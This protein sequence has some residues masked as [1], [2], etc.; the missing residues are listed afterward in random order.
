MVHTK[1]K[2]FKKTLNLFLLLFL[3]IGAIA[4][5]LVGVFYRTEIDSFLSRIK[6]QET[7][8]VSLQG[9]VIGD[10][11]KYIV[12]DLLF[13]AYQNELR[14][15]LNTD[16]ATWTQSVESEYIAMAEHKK[17]YDQLRYLDH[18]GIEKVR[19]NYNSGTPQAVATDQLQDKSQRY[20]FT[21]SIVLNNNQ[22]FV[23]PLDLNIE[24]GAVE[25]PLKPMIRLATPVFDDSGSKRG[26]V[27]INYLAETLLKD[28][29]QSGNLGHGEAMLVNS[30]GDW[31]LNQ[32]HKEDEWIFMFPEKVERKF[33]TSFPEEWSEILSQQHG[34]FETQNGMFTFTTIYP[35]M[36]TFAANNGETLATTSYESLNKYF[37]V[38]V[39]YIPPEH[40]K[41]YKN[42]LLVK[43]FMI[44]SG[45]FLIIVLGSWFTALA[46]T[47]R[48]IYQAELIGMALHDTLTGLANRRLF[49]ENLRKGVDH[50]K[51]F[52]RKLGLLYIDLDGFKEVNDQYG[53]EAGDDLLISVGKTLQSLS[54]SSDTIAR[55]GGDEF[56]CILFEVDSIE[57]AVQ[58]GQKIVE[59][60]RD[61]IKIQGK[62]VTV[63][64]SVGVAV[65]PD[66]GTE[67]EELVRRADKAMYKSK[68]GGKNICTQYSKDLT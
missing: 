5:G 25:L 11:F 16:D 30:E 35:L 55:L 41:E 66:H 54:R 68:V 26:I 8:T 50:D 39:S 2:T 43:M 37:W 45:L 65:Y 58:A 47:K 51:R 27:L 56:A 48:R 52:E 7:H 17:V 40:L 60:L 12:S 59:A 62:T 9:K 49:F 18:N 21:D 24:N 3:I 29:Q 34:Q 38:L 67:P 14:A 6:I 31:L 20:Y 22:V 13:L 32:E 44:G 63:S 19:V 46:I 36:E 64:A 1:T 10:A 28:I 57:G 53:H 23:S 61:P 4:S 42:E 33:T 15:L